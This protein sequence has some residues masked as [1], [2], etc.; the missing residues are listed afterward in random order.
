MSE[1]LL[2]QYTGGGSIETHLNRVLEAQ[3]KKSAKSGQPPAMGGIYRDEE[4]RIWWDE[5]EKVEYD[6][7]LGDRRQHATESYVDFGDEGR[8]RSRTRDRRRPSAI[9]IPPPAQPQNFFDDSFVPKTAPIKDSKKS[10]SNV[11]GIFGMH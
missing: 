3:A 6:S 2:M 11:R 9:Q 8:H 10:R 7:L 5:A 4:G 1:L